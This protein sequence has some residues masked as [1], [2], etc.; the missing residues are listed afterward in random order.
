MG[1]ELG[2]PFSDQ[3]RPP[4]TDGGR[5]QLPGQTREVQGTAAPSSRGRGARPQGAA[6]SGPSL[7][8]SNGWAFPRLPAQSPETRAPS[9]SQGVIFSPLTRSKDAGETLIPAGPWDPRL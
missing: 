6:F 9:V 7:F 3:D 4:I 2:G 8:A 1:R 5:G